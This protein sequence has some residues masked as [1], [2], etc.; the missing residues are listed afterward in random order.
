M[1]RGIFVLLFTMVLLFSSF[2]QP[3]FS[4]S[5][6]SGFRVVN[7]ALETTIQHFSWNNGKLLLYKT[8]MQL[9]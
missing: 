5:F 7:N 1:R 4:G 3:V 8:N 9:Y 6:E 2:T